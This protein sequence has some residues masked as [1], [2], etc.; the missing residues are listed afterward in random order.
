MP[1]IIIH[2]HRENS[3]SHIIINTIFLAEP[4]IAVDKLPEE[5]DMII[6][7]ICFPAP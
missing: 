5:D 6:A 7:I 4:Y 1:H 2:F 3:M